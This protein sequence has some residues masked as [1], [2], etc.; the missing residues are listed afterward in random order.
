MK[1]ET[2]LELLKLAIEY[3]RPFTKSH[4]NIEKNIKHNLSIIREIYF[5]F[6]ASLEENKSVKK[7]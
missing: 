1:E 3:S 4:G 2:K 5:S 7:E 6:L